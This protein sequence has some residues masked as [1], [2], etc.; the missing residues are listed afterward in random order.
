M[1]DDDWCNDKD[2]GY[3]AEKE[4]K[5]REEFWGNEFEEVIGIAT[6]I[7]CH[8]FIALGFFLCVSSW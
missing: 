7:Y 5:R 8:S 2:E 1:E 3:G 6:E 4:V